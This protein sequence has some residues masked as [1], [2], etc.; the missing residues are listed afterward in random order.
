MLDTSV[1]VDSL[2][3]PKHSG[4]AL[5]R[6]L[7]GI[8]GIALSVLVIYEWLRGPRTEREVAMQEYLLPSSAAIPFSLED[9]V[10]SADIYR[11]IRRTGGRARSREI[12]IA[13][14]A[15]AIR[16]KAELWTLNPS[17]FADI[18]GLRLIKPR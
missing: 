16:Q 9:A 4:P 8:E 18:P 13:I 2:T 12:D 5:Q 6:E 11:S 1:L 7:E 17:D 15:C 14:A 10:L 3:G